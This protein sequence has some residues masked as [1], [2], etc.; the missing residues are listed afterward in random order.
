M[1]NM[2]KI[3]ECSS[4]SPET[5]EEEMDSES[6]G[7]DDGISKEEREGKEN[8]NVNVRVEICDIKGR[9]TV[10]ASGDS[11]F[12]CPVT[13]SPG[14]VLNI[15]PNDDDMTKENSA[16]GSKH[17]KISPF[18]PFGETS[19]S[20]FEEEEK[21]K[22][23]VITPRVSG[24]FSRGE[25]KPIYPSKKKKNKREELE[26]FEMEIFFA[27]M[28]EMLCDGEFEGLNIR[29]REVLKQVAGHFI[30]SS[31]LSE[32]YRAFRVAVRRRIMEILNAS[33]SLRIGTSL[34]VDNPEKKNYFLS[35]RYSVDF[36]EI[37]RIGLGGFGQV[38][39]V[40]SNIDGCDYAVKKIQ[41]NLTMSQPVAKIVNEVR[42]LAAVQHK[43]IVRYYG[44]WVELQDLHARRENN[45]CSYEKEDDAWKDLSGG[46][47]EDISSPTAGSSKL[48]QTDED[49]WEDH[50]NSISTRK[51]R[52][53][54]QEFSTASSSTISEELKMSHNVSTNQELAVAKRSKRMDPINLMLPQSGAAVMF[55][56]MEL[57]SRTLSDY[58]AERNADV[59][60]E[61][62]RNFNKSIMEQLMSA[63]AHL[64]SKKIIHRD[65]KPSNV[66]LRDES[67]SPI[68]SV[69]LGDF[70]LA[71]L[72]QTKMACSAAI[73]ES[74]IVTAH[75]VGV[76]TSIYAAPEQQNSNF[77]DNAVDIYS[78]GIV[79]FELCVPIYTQMERVETVG[80]L[81]KGELSEEFKTSFPEEAELIQEMCKM[82]PQERPHAFEIVSKLGKIGGNMVSIQDRI[83]ELEKEV[84]RLKNLLIEH[85]IAEI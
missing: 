13:N 23:W 48:A 25:G 45:N 78:A 54:K 21:L 65:I 30:H 83:Q 77:Y 33:T 11:V 62:D 52:F 4:D 27:S 38:F 14:D 59:K 37:R 85:N 56:Q 44:A 55:V 12:Y 39:H 53:S 70:G 61:I 3:E 51:D 15:K 31:Y 18:S 40:R 66:F 22:R 10:L 84:T 73:A 42:L 29:F 28:I 50:F 49:D 34:T 82:N 8:N 26:H 1:L 71:C 67:S 35:S 36:K 5:A 69:L 64:H 2:V 68:P 79:F 9:C 17:R 60:R 20:S 32:D 7:T 19:N 46:G 24:T 80:K 57:C 63:V 81:K 41:F 75:T 76:G 6:N 58:F 74:K 72:H 43:N 16:D 47:K